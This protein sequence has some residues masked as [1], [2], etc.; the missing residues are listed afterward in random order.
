MLHYMV[1][2]HRK[3]AFPLTWPDWFPSKGAVAMP[4]NGGRRVPGNTSAK[5][6][7][8]NLCS[9]TLN[10]NSKGLR[11]PESDSSSVTAAQP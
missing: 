1:C 3:L 11:S 5:P 2:L 10:G 6:G 4:K 9:A 7:D 8:R